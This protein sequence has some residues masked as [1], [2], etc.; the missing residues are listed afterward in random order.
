MFL[1]IKVWFIS[2]PSAAIVDGIMAVYR[3]HISFVYCI[4]VLHYFI[5]TVCCDGGL[6][7]ESYDH[8]VSGLY[9]WYNY[10][11]VILIMS[12]IRLDLLI[13]V[14]VELDPRILLFDK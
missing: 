8:L 12:Y 11:D 2:K 4:Y 9:K 14:C 7:D 6:F 5:N 13:C 1:K 10:W 3:E